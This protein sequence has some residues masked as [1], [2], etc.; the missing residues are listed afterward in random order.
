[1]TGVQIV[2]Q[3]LGTLQGGQQFTAWGLSQWLSANYSGWAGYAS[4]L[5]Q[6][7]KVA[8]QSGG[9]VHRCYCTRRGPNATWLK[10]HKG[11]WLR[12][13]QIKAQQL[14]FRDL[15]FDYACRSLPMAKAEDARNGHV[16]VQASD[17][18]GPAL[19]QCKETITNQGYS[20]NA[21]L[22]GMGL[23]PVDI[24]RLLARY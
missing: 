19:I 13:M 20:L 3:Y 18:D 7:H 22:V 1:M 23:R 17:P 15:F 10:E 2:D 5:L 11:S 14:C 4:Q 21:M 8:Q 9:T 16:K 24:P 6:M 12:S